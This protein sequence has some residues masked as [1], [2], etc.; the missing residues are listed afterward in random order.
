MVPVGWALSFLSFF[1]WVSLFFLSIS[2][3]WRMVYML[4]GSALATSLAAIWWPVTYVT[5][6]EIR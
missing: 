2:V 1:G 4:I 6:L 3:Y 5:M